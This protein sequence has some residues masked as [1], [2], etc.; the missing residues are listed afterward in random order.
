MYELSQRD[1]E[2]LNAYVMAGTSAKAGED[3]GLA[4]QTV[5][6]KLWLMRLKTRLPT[7]EL[8]VY[9]YADQLREWRKK[10]PA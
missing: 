9:E 10:K 6:Q 5:K 2:V 3:L 1:L 8:L 7:T 4:V